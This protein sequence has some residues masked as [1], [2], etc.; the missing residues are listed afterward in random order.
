MRTTQRRICQ[1]CGDEFEADRE[2]KNYKRKF[3]STR[4]G[5]EAAKKKTRASWPSED[6]MRRLY[7]DEG[8]TD[9]EIGARFGHSY[10]W[11]LTIRQ[12]Y[13][14][15]GRARPKPASPRVQA[16]GYVRLGDE[17]EHRVVAAEKV[18]RALLPG[19]VVHH[20]DGDP[21]N[22][23]PDN[24]VVYPSHSEHIWDERGRR[25]KKPSKRKSPNKRRDWTEPRQKVEAEGRCRV[26]GGTS[27]VQAAHIVPRSQVAAGHGEHVD[28]IVP[29]CG[30][31]GNGCHGL[32]D[33]GELDLLPFLTLGEQAYAVLIHPGGMVGAYQRV[34]GG[35]LDHI[36]A[37]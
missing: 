36:E 23:D 24:L 33:R 21:Q 13:G 6:E 26:C 28:N 35:A 4:C 16:N 30:D 34:T 10:Q 12:A 31:F 15:E 18:G 14:I 3:C 20:I 8:L 9:K 32:F 5:G 19:E 11:A 2:H 37:A 29:L 1:F 25:A 27:D 17:W 22:N 7:E